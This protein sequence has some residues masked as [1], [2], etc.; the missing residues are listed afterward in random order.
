M[1]AADGGFEGPLEGAEGELEVDCVVG[2]GGLEVI[3]V[4]D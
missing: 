4:E 1:V 2:F 3:V